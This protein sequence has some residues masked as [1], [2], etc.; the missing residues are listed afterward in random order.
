MSNYLHRLLT[1]V[2]G[3]IRTRKTDTHFSHHDFTAA[4]I[5][6][7]SNHVHLAGILAPVIYHPVP[8]QT[9]A[10]LESLFYEIIRADLGV[11]MAHLV[12]PDLVALTELRV[13]EMW[14]PVGEQGN[15]ERPVV[16]LGRDCCGLRFGLT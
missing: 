2:K 14:F 9:L 3:T 15:P 16:S 5:A 4:D 8:H 10:R 6:R 11:R 7:E 1:S 13:P 12:M